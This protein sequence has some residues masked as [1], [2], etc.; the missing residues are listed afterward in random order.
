MSS[1]ALPRSC[2]GLLIL[3]VDENFYF[4]NAPRLENDLL[5]IV[6]GQK[7]LSCLVLILSGVGYVDASGL[8]MLES[9]ERSLRE[10]GITLHLSEVKGPVMDRLAGTELL[11]QLDDSRIHLTTDSAVRRL[12]ETA[13]GPVDLARPQKPSRDA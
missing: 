7:D 5:N 10:K 13:S 3:R 12:A 6:A 2:P 1:S 4:A 8:Q 11:Q 9:F